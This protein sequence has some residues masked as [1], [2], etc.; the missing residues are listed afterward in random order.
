MYTL[1]G[2]WGWGPDKCMQ[3]HTK[4]T[5][6]GVLEPFPH[7]LY[8]HM[9]TLFGKD[10]GSPAGVLST[11]MIRKVLKFDLWYLKII[12]KSL[13]TSFSSFTTSDLVI[14]WGHIHFS[15]FGRKSTSKSKGRRSKSFLRKLTKMFSSIG[16]EPTQTRVSLSGF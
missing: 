1:P 5:G 4:Y 7:T 12:C 6:G 3:K 13:E 9:L 2:G 14:I 11:K 16:A 8:V 15:S 10:Q